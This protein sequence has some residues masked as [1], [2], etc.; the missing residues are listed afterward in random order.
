M[1][2]MTMWIQQSRLLVAI[3]N[4]DLKVAQSL[5]ESGVDADLRFKVG[6]EKRPAICLCVERGHAQMAKLLL[7]YGCS[8]NQ[9]D[10]CGGFT[11]LHIASAHGHLEVAEILLKNRANVKV[12]DNFGHT[13]MHLA[14]QHSSLEIVKLLVEFGSEI[15][16]IDYDD[17][18]PLSIACARGNVD[19]VQYLVSKGANVNSIDTSCNTPLMHA[20]SGPHSRVELVNILVNAGAKVNVVNKHGETPLLSIIRNSKQ[21]AEC[22]KSVDV[23]TAL[24]ESGCDLNC[25]TPLGQSPLHLAVILHH[26]NMVDLLAKFGCDPNTKDSLGLTPLFHLSV[27]GKTYLVKLIATLG[28][29]P[30]KEE[31]LC[32]SRRISE[33]LNPDLQRWILETKSTAPS[34]KSLCRLV[35]RKHFGIKADSLILKLNLPVTII[36]YLSL[37]QL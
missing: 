19:I 16:K 26:D 37:A 15:D 34:L 2:N 8:I 12:L 25:K 6:P 1:H 32:D 3:Q 35:I 14:S 22:Q 23:M 36:N 4:N 10:P 20:V 30:S 9:N 31:W 5:L 7:Q 27:S 24:V 17:R 13:P 18:T 29:N 11:P 21:L 28:A 33:I